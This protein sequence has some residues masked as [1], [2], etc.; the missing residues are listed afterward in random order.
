MNGKAVIF[1]A[2]SGAGKTTI[3][4]YLLRKIRKLEFSISATTRSPR[5][6]EKDG[7]DYYFLSSV[8]FHKKIDSGEILEWQE[9]YKDTYYGTLRSEVSRI[10]ENGNH[11]IFDVD[12]KG[13]I[14]LKK[15]FGDQALSVFI[16]VEN[17]DILKE[18]LE[19]RNT[20]SKETLNERVA[21]AIEE[22]REES[23]FDVVIV[24][25]DLDVAL[26][27][28]EEIVNNFLK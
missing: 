1:C 7:S 13:G 9:V 18:R 26:E 21:K 2:P 22:M 10:W 11:V 19:G 14:N 25:H 17:L 24:N 27:E 16:K 15:Q 20:E 6:N 4:R 23:N 8:D 28:A 3:V 5:S 12:V